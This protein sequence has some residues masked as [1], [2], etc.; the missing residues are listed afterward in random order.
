MSQENLPTLDKSLI[1]LKQELLA[2]IGSKGD[3][4]RVRE[5]I[6]PRIADFALAGRETKF[7]EV[8]ED[9]CK[10]YK[11]PKDEHKLLEDAITSFVTKN[12]ETIHAVSQ[13]KEALVTPIQKN[14]KT[15]NKTTEVPQ[16]ETPQKK[17]PDADDL[18]I[19]QKR[20]TP[21][22][23]QSAEILRNTPIVQKEKTPEVR[24][25]KYVEKK[26]SSSNKF[27]LNTAELLDQQ[28]KASYKKI[29]AQ[30]DKF[31]DTI[32][33]KA[34][35]QA[36]EKKIESIK[37]KRT[38]SAITK[39]EPTLTQKEPITVEPIQIASTDTYT[40]PP[41]LTPLRSAPIA[42][43]TTS[44]KTSMME[45]TKKPET[46]EKKKNLDQLIDEILREPGVREKIE[47][48]IANAQEHGIVAVTHGGTYKVQ[49]DI[50]PK[51]EGGLSFKKGE[52]VLTPKP[53]FDGQVTGFL[54]NQFG[55]PVNEQQFVKTGTKFDLENEQKGDIYF[56]VAENG[57]ILQVYEDP[58][59]GK[60]HITFGNHFDE[61]DVK[62]SSADILYRVLKK[63]NGKKGV[64]T[65]SNFP[66]INYGHLLDQ[67]VATPQADIDAIN[68]KRA[69]E[70][71]E[72]FPRID[73]YQFIEKT[74]LNQEALEELIRFT[75]DADNL[76]MPLEIRKTHKKGLSE[77]VYGHYR[78]L[79]FEKIIEHFA[80]GKK[81]TDPLDKEILEETVHQKT[82]RGATKEEIEK[83]TQ[84]IQQEIIVERAKKNPTQPLTDTELKELVDKK[85]ALFFTSRKNR[86]LAHISNAETGIENA[87][88]EMTAW[89]MPEGTEK[90]GRV[91]IS[92]EKNKTSKIATKEVVFAKK[93]NYDSL[94]T[95]N[96]EGAF[97][98]R[99]GHNL[100]EIYETIKEKY[101]E[102]VFQNSMILYYPEKTAFNEREFLHA[103]GVDYAETKKEDTEVKR[104]NLKKGLTF[105]DENNNLVSIESI[106]NEIVTLTSTL[107]NKSAEHIE[108]LLEFINTGV[109]TPAPTLKKENSGAEQFNPLDVYKNTVTDK[110]YTITKSDAEYVYY[111]EAGK[112]GEEKTKI[113]YIKKMVSEGTFKKVE[114]EVIL[115]TPEEKEEKPIIGPLT[116]RAGL[117][118]KLH[119]ELGWPEEILKFLPDSDIVAINNNRKLYTEAKDGPEYRE[120]A[121][122]HRI[123]KINAE[124]AIIYD[125]MNKREIE[126]TNIRQQIREYKNKDNQTN[127]KPQELDTEK[128]EKTT[129]GEPENISQPIELSVEDTSDTHQEEKPDAPTQKE[130]Y[131]DF[132]KIKNSLGDSKFLYKLLTDKYNQIGFKKTAELNKLAGIKN[133][134]GLSGLVTAYITA[135]KANTNIDL[136][137]EMEKTLRGL[138][139]KK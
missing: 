45:P 20:E 126:I 29:R 27:D 139:D 85:L 137:A 1:S 43:D 22:L 84:L 6:L 114:K 3:N 14:T 73:H 4:A 131:I 66:A 123:E 61:R 15:P 122:Q 104:A 52:K 76:M 60:I 42:I 93:F 18:E 51:I 5:N 100:R 110:Q 98:S 97:V 72:P 40:I 48:F 80:S 57:K 13:K 99:P 96:E 55:I 35:K 86:T 117:E 87:E 25:S 108:T 64:L 68:Q 37:Q 47:K 17:I 8:L 78:T 23:T 132:E 79:P 56:D 26:T 21:L 91:L 33:S 10:L 31:I 118:K 32:F 105:F 28:E 39:P 94:I 135:K 19:K 111:R 138:K 12:K 2:N 30:G 63:I 109:F 50:N 125:R 53:D 120:K 113:P 83:K 124:L 44:K 41:E 36:F 112:T 136:V 58:K 92:N 116:N 34:K 103:I 11:I 129:A 70:G 127:T 106:K 107:G 65:M 38:D 62:T 89:S 69:E 130:G 7:K 115:E 121:R 75:N 49:Q 9:Y 24:G 90:L 59:T 82:G 101:P 134:D 128:T 67:E 133:S 102:A 88:K 16:N 46:K 54:L 95:F 119:T 71:M 74:P 81:A 77:T